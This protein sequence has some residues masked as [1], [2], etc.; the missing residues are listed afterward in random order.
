MW[1]DARMKVKSATGPW[2]GRKRAAG[3]RARRACRYG[4]RVELA[5]EHRG[6]PGLGCQVGV[7]IDRQQHVVRVAGVQYVALADVAQ[8]LPLAGA[9]RGGPEEEV[10]VGGGGQEVSHA[11]RV[12]AHVHTVQ[13]AGTQGG[14]QAVELDGRHG[15]HLGPVVT[16]R[17]GRDLDAPFGQMYLHHA[18]VRHPAGQSEGRQVLDHPVADVAHRRDLDQGMALRLAR[19]PGHRRGRRLG[20]RR[21]AAVRCTLVKQRAPCFTR[22]PR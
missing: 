20:C 17:H 5:H 9:L 11:L 7:E 13:C 21:R 22:H 4:G 12:G 8:Q 3:K 2:L 1:W 6:Q 14:C 10:A 18:S 19:L 15:D 16:L